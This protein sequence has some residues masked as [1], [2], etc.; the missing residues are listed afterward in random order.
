VIN[1]L[2]FNDKSC[3]ISGS[4]KGVGYQLSVEMARLGAFLYINGRSHKTTEKVVNNIKNVT[5]NLNIFN[6]YGDISN[7]KDIDRILNIISKTTSK[8]DI[9]INNAGIYESKPFLDSNYEEIFYNINNNLLGHINLILN[10][11]KLMAKYG[12]G[13]IIN[14]SSGSGE[15]GGNLPS[16]AYSLSKN[17]LNFI[18]K[19]LYNELRYYKINIVTIVLHYVN[20]RMLKKYKNL[21]KKYNF[22]IKSDDVLKKS[23]VSKSIINLLKHKKFNKNLIYIQ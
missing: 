12:G 9:L 11:S 20:T 23:E 13:I 8:L 21:S 7:N 14:I 1:I 10:V 3:F 17:A 2:E 6:A 19:I 16:F 4:T 18:P 5:G 22:Y 15:H